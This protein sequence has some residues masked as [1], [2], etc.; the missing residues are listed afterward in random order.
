MKEAYIVT[1]LDMISSGNKYGKSG[2]FVH[3]VMKPRG[4]FEP[5]T[6]SYLESCRLTA[7]HYQ[8]R[9]IP[10]SH[11]GNLTFTGPVGFEPTTFGLEA[12]RYILAKPRA[13]KRL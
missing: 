13:H 4:G 1:S 6:S 3:Y 9:A 8:G 7:V 5:P 10:L 2:L 12:R 11:R